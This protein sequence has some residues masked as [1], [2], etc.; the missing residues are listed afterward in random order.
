MLLDKLLVQLKETG[1]CVLIFSQMVRMLD[2]LADYLTFKR[3]TF[4]VCVCVCVCVCQRKTKD[5]ADGMR[6]KSVHCPRRDSNLYLWDTRPSCFRLHH[7]GRYAS[8]QSKQTLQAL[9]RQLDRETIMHE[10]LQLLSAGPRRQASARTAAEPDEACQRKT[11]DRADGMREKSAHC[12][13]RD[14]NVYLMGYA[15][16]VLPITPRRQAR[17]PSVAHTLQTL[18]RHLDRETITHETLQ[19]LSAGPRHQASAR[20]STES[21]EACQRKTKDRADG[22]REKSAHCPR[23]DVCACVCVCVRVCVRVCAC[24]HACVCVCVC[25]T[26]K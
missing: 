7:D 17:L 14:S 13:R 16:I 22:M 23:R 12:P 8:R 26:M 25:V 21:D 10:T 5:R 4:Q 19:I 15:P 11:K 6:E 3:F 18:T 20:T 2:I 24:V 1:H 9:T